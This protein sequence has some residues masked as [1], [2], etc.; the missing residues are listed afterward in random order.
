MKRTKGTKGGSQAIKNMLNHI[1]ES[2][3]ERVLD[4]ATKEIAGY[5]EH[6]K[7]DPALKEG[8][9]TLGYYFDREREEGK[10]EDRIEAILELLED[11]GCVPDD[12]RTRLEA[13]DDLD[14]LKRLHKVAAKAGSIEEF[15]AAM[16][17]EPVSA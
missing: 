15:E 2:R 3:P 5:V 8:S 1:Q 16:A 14:E 13:V 10:K 11:I 17:K 4:E 7:A 12:M 6:V 9:M